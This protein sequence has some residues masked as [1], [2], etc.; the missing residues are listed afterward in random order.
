[1]H[2]INKPQ[3]CRKAGL[4]PTVNNVHPGRRMLSVFAVTLNSGISTRRNVTTFAGASLQTQLPVSA[5]GFF[6]PLCF[7][8]PLCWTLYLFI[9]PAS[10][11]LLCASSSRAPLKVFNLSSPA[12]LSSARLLHLWALFAVLCFF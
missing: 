1:M 2:S 7:H 3:S 11:F 6:F 10:E 12:F 9:N 5:D 8:G 4:S